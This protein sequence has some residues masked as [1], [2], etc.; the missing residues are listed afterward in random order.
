MA[1]GDPV[2]AA[3]DKCLNLLLG[4]SLDRSGAIVA[5]IANSLN[6]HLAERYGEMRGPSET[7]AGGLA[8]WQLRLATRT[9]KDFNSSSSLEEIATACGLSIGHFSRAFKRSTGSSPHQWVMYRRVEA[10]KELIGGSDLP[11]AEIA[12]ACHFSDQSHLTRA[13]VS[14]TG[15]TPGRWRVAPHARASASA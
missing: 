12:L 15:T 5:G 9:L 6:V 8:P 10:A 3:L 2:M 11:L 1:A 14:A 13:F 4:G 7:T